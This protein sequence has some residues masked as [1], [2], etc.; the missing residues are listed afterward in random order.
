MLKLFRLLAPYRG[1]VAIVLVLALAQSIGFLLL[2]RL[3]SDI[4]DKGIVKGDQ[5]AIL[6]IG[7]LMLLMSTAATLCAIAGMYYASKVATGFGRILRGAIFA[8]V[9]HF[10]I[11]QFDRFGSASLVTRTTNDTTQVQQMLTMM[12]TMVITAPMMAT[13]GVILALS[14]DTQLAWVLIAVMPVMALVFGFILRG[15]VPLSQAMQTKIDRLNLVIGEGLSGVRV[16]RAFDRGAQQRERFDR[17]NLDLT[18]TA[19]ALNRLMAF[20]LPA[21]IVMLNLTS[22]A[23]IWVGSH[24]I[25]AGVMQVGAMIASLQYAMQIL[26]AVFMVTA[27]F[28]MLPRASASAARINEVL[29]VAPEIVDPTQGAEP[30]RAAQRGHVEFQDV[31]FQYPGAEEPALTGV[32]FEAH[33]GEMTAIIGGTGSG[34]STLAGLIPRFYDVNHGRVLVDG[35]D[36]REMTQDDLRARIG[37]V[38]QKA[39]LFTGTVAT[40]IRYGREGASDEEVRHAATV[41]QAI[42]F[43]DAMPD[44]FAAPISQGGINLSGGQKQRLSIARAIVRKPDVY[45]FDDSFSALDFTT[46]AK[47]RAALKAETGNAT[48]FIVAQRISTVIN[49]DRIIVLDNGRVAGIG[50]HDQLLES[51]EI[52]REIVASQVSL[53]EVA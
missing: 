4:V 49:A 12:L 17:A 38:P 52:Y 13:G 10:S 28:V 11:H 50:P 3:M 46:D 7:G 31:T 30:P 45:V 22:L 5:R 15:A 6:E 14:Q 47:L 27:M 42:E 25:D 19:I 23:I 51:N 36:V 26:F 16:I 40:N 44:T 35:V 2:P 24:R 48:V 34:K 53:G 9:E 8:R 32:S 18:N 37:F 21:L 29:D 33:P 43:V 20:L 39:V 1:Y 41:A